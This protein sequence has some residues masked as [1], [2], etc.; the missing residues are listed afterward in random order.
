MRLMNV[1]CLLC[2][3]ALAASIS[4]HGQPS[5]P[6]A[7]ELLSRF[8][9]APNGLARHEYLTSVM[10]LLSG[11]DK[12][13]ALQ[14]L[15]TVDSE[16]G[17]YNEA[18]MAFPFDNRIAPPK[19]LLLPQ[20]NQW[21][22]EDAAAA[23]A[24]MA[25]KRRIV[26]VNEAHHDAHTRELTLALLPR[27]RALGFQYFAVEA[28]S[29]KDTDLMHRGYVTDTSGSEYILEPLYGEI[30]RQAIR[31]GYTV[32]AYDPEDVSVADRDTAQARILY[33]KVFA[34]DP[35]A[36]LFVHA[37]YAHIDKMAGNLGGS[38]Q[39]L[40]MQ[41]KRLSSEDPLCVDQVQFRDVAVGGLDFG[42]YNT[43]ASQF[44]SPVPY[45]LRQHGGDTIWSSDPKQH[46][47]TVVV[48]PASERDLD[49]HGIMHSDVL[50][51]EVLM[52]RM[53]L[54]PNQR[55]PWLTLG[56]KRMSY[57][58]SAD[59]CAGKIPCVIDAHY[60]GEPDNATPADRYTFLHS[61]SHNELF[62]YP[63]H[64]R[65][66]SWDAAGKTLQQEEIEVPPN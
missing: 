54:D 25:A 21:Q 31:L 39:P 42:F 16:L 62:L 59:L 49:V 44:S 40:A 41:L 18:M 8:G 17:L 9:S 7:G 47:V 57:R 28:L 55:P 26:M 20:A 60:P 22:V 66:H 13:L 46:D 6:S 58:I 11:D 4:A 52:P 27:L 19:S 36:K 32:V 12:S 64:Y 37:G 35:Q 61:R 24:E 43:V 15:A 5:P 56:G 1:M 53:P 2:T 48:P 3:T 63:G 23:V 14:L 50:R 45:A 29:A 30:V 33:E 38:I 51:R 10:P 34:K 65:L